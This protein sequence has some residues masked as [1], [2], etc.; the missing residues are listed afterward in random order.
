MGLR[1]E[2]KNDVWK[3][4]DGNKVPE[5]RENKFRLLVLQLLLQSQGFNLGEAFH[6]ADKLE[7]RYN[8]IIDDFD[9]YI[10]DANGDLLNVLKNV[11]K[12]FDDKILPLLEK[13]KRMN[14]NG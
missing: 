1:K 4:I 12:D 13:I 6:V 11:D 8:K 10:N 2:L 14:K 7:A 5:E 3:V 9:G